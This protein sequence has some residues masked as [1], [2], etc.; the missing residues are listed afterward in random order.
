[1][2]YDIVLTLLN[3]VSGLALTSIGIEMANNP[4][5]TK[6]KKWKYRS[7]FM[8]FGA[9]VIA[10]TLA[11]SIRTA[12][13]QEHARTEAKQASDAAHQDQLK[14]QTTMGYMQGTLDAIAKFEAQYLA[15]PIS[16]GSSKEDLTFALAIM[17]MAQAKPQSNL[18]SYLNLS[19]DQLRKEVEDMT[20]R[21]KQKGTEYRQ[22]YS[23]LEAEARAARLRRE[24]GKKQDTDEGRIK[25]QERDLLNRFMADEENAELCAKSNF[26]WEI[27]SIKIGDSQTRGS[28]VTAPEVFLRESDR[29]RSLVSR[30]PL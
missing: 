28:C 18:E 23:G 5:D 4:L 17:K 22:A 13:E 15:H 14:S 12:K 3:V 25:S 16:S 7:L 9:A 27:I 19:N 10:T 8:I 1:M 2:D 26:L 11:Q 24:S 6:A 20:D 21:L 29:L 30:L